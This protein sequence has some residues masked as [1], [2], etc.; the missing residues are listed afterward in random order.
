MRKIAGSCGRMAAYTANRGKTLMV[1]LLET[2]R[3]AAAEVARMN[4]ASRA[5]LFGSYARGTATARS[6]VDII[7]VEETSLPFLKRLD[8]YFDPL[9]DRL[10]APVETIVYTPQEFD[11]MRGMPFVRQALEEGVILY[12]SGKVPS[13]CQPLADAGTGRSEGSRE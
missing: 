6:D 9:A 8:R 13:G 10:R 3:E 11:R 5:I 2:I 12:E 4:G 1:I 7:F